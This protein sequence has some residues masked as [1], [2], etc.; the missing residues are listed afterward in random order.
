MKRILPACLLLF[1]FLLG[2]QSIDIEKRSFHT[3]LN[4]S[5]QKVYQ[6][7]GHQLEENATLVVKNVKQFAKTHYPQLADSRNDLKL[8][9]VKTSQLGYHVTFEQTHLLVPI[10]GTQIKVNITPDFKI[11]NVFA[12]LVYTNE[13]ENLN[14][15]SAD[16]ANSGSIIIFNGMYPQMGTLS[17]RFDAEANTYLEELW[18][19]RGFY[20]SRDLGRYLTNKQDLPDSLVHVYVYYPDPITS[21]KTIYGGGFKNIGGK[22]TVTLN[23]ARKLKT[24]L[25]KYL[26]DSFWAE[27]KYVEMIDPKVQK[28]APAYSRVDT[29]DFVRS[30]PEFDQMNALFHITNYHEHLTAIGY[31]TLANYKIQ[32]NTRG[33]FSD[34]S[35]FNRKNNSGGQGSLEYGYGDDQGNQHVDDAEDADVIIHEFGHALSY[36]AN[37]NKL[38]SHERR[39]LD[40]GICD[41]LACSYSR[42]ISAY[43]WEELF[44]WDGQNEFWEGRSCTT[45]QT[46]DDYSGDHSIYENGEI[47]AGTLMMLWEKLGRDTT[48]ALLIGTLYLLAENTSFPQTARLMLDTDSLLNGGRNSEVICKLF[49]EQRFFSQSDCVA[50]IDDP[51]AEGFQVDFLRFSNEQEL[52]VSWTENQPATIR[53]YDMGGKLLISN[54]LTSGTFTENVGHL[55]AG[56]YLLEARVENQIF[57]Q[58]L[59]KR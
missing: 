39:S 43:A 50:G 13:W 9:A 2:A 32:V 33:L 49:T 11:L 10:Y 44:N 6:Y 26:A 37:E 54:R 16:D 36:H 51:T 21:E 41:Y 18:G 34:Q 3:W 52:K 7:R 56:V 20:Y 57:R 40:E 8:E 27:N 1:P 45:K 23:D 59:V 35:R 29:F 17:E 24:T 14:T 47:L 4:Q 42:D 53:L 30:Q 48:D 58:R 28:F 25:V 12:K 5:A 46:F 22:D 19:E 31:D 15:K 38:V 55:G